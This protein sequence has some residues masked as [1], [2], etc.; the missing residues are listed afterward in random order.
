MSY[1]HHFCSSLSILPRPARCLRD[2]ETTGEQNPAT[3]PKPTC[4]PNPS[5]KPKT[6]DEPELVTEPEPV[7]EPE[8]AYLPYCAPDE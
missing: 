3:E 1:P 7:T 5:C 2:P 4:D 6:A 8:W